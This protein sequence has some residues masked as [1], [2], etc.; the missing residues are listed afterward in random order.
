MLN[1]ETTA[2]DVQE[3]NQQQ[4]RHLTSQPSKVVECPRRDSNTRPQ[5]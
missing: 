1:T 3:A 4:P 5:D 2:H